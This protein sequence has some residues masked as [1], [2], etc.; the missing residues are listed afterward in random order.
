MV[1]GD[2]YMVESMNGYPKDFALGRFFSAVVLL[3]VTSCVP[4][5]EFIFN[6]HSGR[7][8]TLMAHNESYSV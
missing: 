1:H 8:L 5:F 7:D 2:L 3:C 6:N 4:Q